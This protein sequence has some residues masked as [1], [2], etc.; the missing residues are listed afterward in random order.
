MSLIPFPVTKPTDEQKQQWSRDTIRR[1]AEFGGRVYELSESGKVYV[2]VRT[3]SAPTKPGQIGILELVK[4]I[5]E[6][7]MTLRL[8]INDKAEPYAYSED[9]THY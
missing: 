5:N 2:L 6:P 9:Q 4:V 8:K 1:R 3:S 7:D